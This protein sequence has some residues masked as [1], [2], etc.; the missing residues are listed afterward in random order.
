M[1]KYCKIY[2]M[3]TVRIPFF[4]PFNSSKSSSNDPPKTAAT[5]A[6][7][8]K[9]NGLLDDQKS[10][11]PAITD[12]HTAPSTTITAKDDS[13][14]GPEVQKSAM[15]SAPQTSIESKDEG[16]GA[17]QQRSSTSI[18]IRSQ[19]AKRSSFEF[20]PKVPEQ[21]VQ[22]KD[23]DSRRSSSGRNVVPAMAESSREMNRMSRESRVEPLG[24]PPSFD[25]QPQSQ[26]VTQGT[27]VTFKC[28]GK[29]GRLEGI[30]M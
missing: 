11:H 4:P 1:C 28:Q 3:F 22:K 13:A 16:L 5:T 18:T 7:P 30:E 6:A 23:P 20:S 15:T 12:T 9:S 10:T 14:T 26:E 27:K 17:G 29:H 19:Q 25:L 21:V 2:L 24:S 8:H